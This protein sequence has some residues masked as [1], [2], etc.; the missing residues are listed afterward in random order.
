[1]R[2]IQYAII[3][4]KTGKAHKVGASLKQAQE[5]LKDLK[6]VNPKMDLV[7]GYKWCS[8]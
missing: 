8:F 4:K 1:M 7:I 3:D 2:L 6:E 5:R